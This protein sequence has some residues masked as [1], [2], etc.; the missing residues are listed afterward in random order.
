MKSSFAITANSDGRW[1]ELYTTEPSRKVAHIIAVEHTTS[2]AA[3]ASVLAGCKWLGSVHVSNP[4]NLVGRIAATIKW[5]PP[6]MNAARH[7]LGSL[8][9][10]SRKSPR[11]PLLDTNFRKEYPLQR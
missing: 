4:S 11:A 3:C 2:F 6:T 9:C 10:A 7:C 5:R 1:N 8:T